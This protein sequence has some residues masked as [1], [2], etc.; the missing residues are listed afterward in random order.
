VAFKQANEVDSG[1]QDHR[2]RFGPY[3]HTRSRFAH[4]Q[5][6]AG[7]L[8]SLSVLMI[9]KRIQAH[10]SV[11]TVGALW[12]AVLM[13]LLKTVGIPL[14][15]FLTPQTDFRIQTIAAILLRTFPA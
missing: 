3:L 4:E 6:A 14:R 7:G 8:V 10:Y 12:P 11:P 15:V 9:E 1:F 5:I 13:P 2:R